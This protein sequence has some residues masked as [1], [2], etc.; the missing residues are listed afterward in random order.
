MSLAKHP[1]ILAFAEAVRQ[2]YDL[3]HRKPVVH[4]EGSVASVHPQNPP[5]RSVRYVAAFVEHLESILE[6]CGFK[7]VD[8]DGYGF[9]GHGLTAWIENV[10]VSDPETADPIEVDFVEP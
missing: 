6:S 9:E 5:Y 8:R 3:D 10:D 1:A 2:E 7:C 4:M